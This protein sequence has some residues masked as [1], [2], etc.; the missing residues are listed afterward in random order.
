VQS[1]DSG[2]PRIP[3]TL[4]W[5][6]G[7]AAATAV[8][9]GVSVYI[10]AF[11]VK[12]LT[13]PVLFTTLKNGVA[14]VIL[15]G[16]LMASDR[17]RATVPRLGGRQWLGL[18]TIG[19]LGGGLA[20]ILFFEGLA[21]ASAPSAAF[22][23]STLFI[24]VAVLAVPLLGERV[25]WVQLAALGI[26][27][28]AQLLISAPAGMDWGGGGIM[29]AAATVLWAIEVIVARRLLQNIPSSVG[30]AGRMVIGLIVLVGYLVLSGRSGAITTLS[31]TQWSWVLATGVL[32]AGYVATWYAA[33]QRAPATVVTCVLVAAAP[34]TVLLSAF[35]E[36]QL[37]T[38]GPLAGYGLVLAGVVAMA[39]VALR[40]GR[41]VPVLFR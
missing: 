41:P 15:V 28:A 29:I 33:L 9:S 22:I 25:G 32:L 11:A 10:N 36:G 21:A 35:G 3:G 8:I 20:F 7:L 14:A 30:A 19:F 23:H 38:V 2:T 37:P 39:W 12:Q 16:L 31:A 6:I 24:W 27:L 26:L 34:I 18:A 1:R 40:V 5:G 13:D 4:G 17:T